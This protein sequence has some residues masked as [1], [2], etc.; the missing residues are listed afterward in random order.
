MGSITNYLENELLDHVLNASYTPAATIYLCLCTADPTD[1]ATGASMNEV[2]NSGSYARTAITFDAAAS[3]TVVQAAAVTFPTA[4]GSWGTITHW[5]IADSGTHGAGNVL[6]TGALAA[7]KSV[8]S[9][10]TPSVADAEIEISFTAGEISNFLA[11]ELL[12][13]AFRNS[14]Y[15]KPD[16]YVGL[17]TATVSDSNTGSTITEVSGGSYARVQVNIN[18]GSTPTWDVAASGLV[19]NTHDIDFPTATASW[20]TVVGVVICDASSA[21]NL[22]FYDNTMGDQAVGDDD[23]VSFPAGDLDV[24]MT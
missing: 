8:I 23:S 2:A 18:G 11:L 17:V 7:S 12:D 22:L 19:D 14:A 16:T 20:G 3:R 13:H 9:G 1:A 4:T 5:A 21:G 6:A 15:S 24:V 10:N